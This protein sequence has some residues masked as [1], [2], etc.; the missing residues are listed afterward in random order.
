MVPCDWILH[1]AFCCDAK[2]ALCDVV[3]SFFPYYRHMSIFWQ[4]SYV[5]PVRCFLEFIFQACFQ[6]LRTSAETEDLSTYA[7]ATVLR[8]ILTYELAVVSS[9]LRMFA[10]HHVKV[11]VFSIILRLRKMTISSGRSTLKAFS[12]KVLN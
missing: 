9:C 1:T 8:L 10:S 6:S 11:I 5:L 12:K 2:V 7:D 3:K 4:W